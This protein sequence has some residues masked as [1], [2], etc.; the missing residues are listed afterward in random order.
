MI[1]DAF[2]VLSKELFTASRRRGLGL[3]LVDVLLGC[4]FSMTVVHVDCGCS[5]T[6]ALMDQLNGTKNRDRHILCTSFSESRNLAERGNT[7]LGSRYSDLGNVHK[8]SPFSITA[9]F[10]L[11]SL[12]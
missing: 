12:Q 9:F 7:I 3:G 10:V 11:S 6:N 1:H 2:S 5:W 4:H 8:G